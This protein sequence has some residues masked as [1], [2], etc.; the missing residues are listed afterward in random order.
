LSGNNG[1][2]R[3]FTGSASKLYHDATINSSANYSTGKTTEE[4]QSEAF[5]QLLGEPF[6][7]A[8]GN[9]PYIEGLPMIGEDVDFST[10]DFRLNRGALV[11]GKGSIRYYREFD[12]TDVSKAVSRAEAGETVYLKVTPYK[13]MLLTD[14]SL[15][16]TNDETGE[17]IGLTAVADNIWMFVMPES[18]VTVTATFVS[19]SSSPSAP[20]APA[21]S[22]T[23]TAST[24]SSNRLA[25]TSDASALLPAASAF[26][27]GAGATL[28]G[29]R[30]RNRR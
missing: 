25:R 21:L 28:A 23:T 11:S 5:A 18:N 4:M 19:A 10:T 12:G 29:L 6:I 20:A 7:Y 8:E 24:S 22:R 13:R 1:T 2:G 16:V 26:F 3:V 14:G 30:R 17:T 27:A 9:Y 15:T